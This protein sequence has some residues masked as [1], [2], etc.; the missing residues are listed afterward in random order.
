MPPQFH[1][2]QSAQPRIATKLRVG[3]FELTNFYQG[4]TVRKFLHQMSE[5]AFITRAM[6]AIGAQQ[7]GMIKFYFLPKKGVQQKPYIHSY[8]FVYI[9][10][11]LTWMQ[12][13]SQCELNKSVASLKYETLCI[14]FIF[15]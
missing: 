9:V 10:T 7:K 15:L 4:A 2:C 5:R 3:C 1:E 12:F 11:S 6:M 13:C 8:L 14:N